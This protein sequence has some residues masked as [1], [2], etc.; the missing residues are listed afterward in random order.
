MLQEKITAFFN[1]RGEL[2][3][4]P[5]EKIIKTMMDKCKYIDDSGL[6]RHN[7]GNRPVRLNYIPT[8]INSP[9]FEK[10]LLNALELNEN[11]NI[12]RSCIELLWGD[13]QLGKRVHACI[14]MWFSVY[15]L[16]RPVLYIFRNLSIDQ[17]Q[18]QEDISGT[19][20]YDF[21]TQ[22]IKNIFLEFNSELQTA[23]DDSSD[24]YW[25]EYRLPDMKDITSKNIGKLGDK[26][27]MNPTDIFCCLMNHVQLEKIDTKFS[28]YVY[29]NKELVN[30][31]VLVDESDLM[32]PTSS[33]D[34]KC[35]TIHADTTKCEQYLAKI[36][37]KSKYVLLI[38]GTA[39][40]LLYNVSTTIHSTNQVV[41]NVVSKVHKMVRSK[42]YYGL[43]ND[44]IEFNTQS[45]AWWEKDN[46]DSD[47][48]LSIVSDD[49]STTYDIIKDYGINIKRMITQIVDRPI[50][51]ISY[52]SLLIS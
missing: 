17:R 52:N 32:A 35:N 1:R 34:G 24:D 40:S 28:E 18:L 16:R 3:K 37:K 26:N 21:N 46:D 9:S 13:I 42:D 45:I 39:H 11:D 20:E 29:Y 7:W 43:F 51:K 44:A 25:M 15:I 33:N 10:D 12:D 36:Y 5:L 22:F 27:G 30:I 50:D 6:E 48:D 19:G 38:T 31:T 4:K 2:L 41:R 49:D 8:N 47:D 14:V 23:F